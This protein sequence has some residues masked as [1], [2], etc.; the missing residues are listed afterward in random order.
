MRIFLFG[1]LQIILWIGVLFVGIIFLWSLCCPADSHVLFPS[2][3]I[4]LTPPPD[5]RPVPGLLPAAPPA[6]GLSRDWR[7]L[8]RR[9]QHR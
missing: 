2:T 7:R 6:G 3:L 1:Y 5:P 4:L 9:R 8:L